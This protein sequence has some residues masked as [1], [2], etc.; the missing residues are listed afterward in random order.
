MLRWLTL[1]P[2]GLLWGS[3]RALLDFITSLPDTAVGCCCP[4]GSLAAR[5]RKLSIPVFPF[6]LADL[7][8]KGKV[9]RFS[10]LVGLIRATGG[11]RPH[12]LHVNQAGAT[13]LA[14]AASRLFRIPCVVHLRLKEDIDYLDRLQPSP[15]HLSHLITISESIDRL[16][17]DRP[18]LRRLRRTL[19]LDAYIPRNREFLTP[20]RREK[21]TSQWDF[22]CVGR[23]SPSKGQ[24]LLLE[25]LILLHER[26]L[27]F[28]AI[29]VGELNN[30]E[31]KM[32]HRAQMA[33]VADS[34]E[35]AGHSDCVHELIEASRWLVC[36][37]AYEPLGRVLFE[38]WD[39]GRPAVVGAFAGGAAT[40]VISSGGGLLFPEWTAQPLASVL[41]EALA[42]DA[43]RE[44]DLA[45]KGYR[46][47]RD[48]T[49]PAAY[50]RRFGEI[51][52]EAV[53]ER[54][55]ASK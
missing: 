25:A 41:Q 23:F 29:F 8:T 26:K 54:R 18:A 43:S 47:M 52:R 13:R 46:W 3:E 38:A 40:S 22:I 44:Q 32:K 55:H 7:H 10:A 16:V 9:K 31:L 14:L 49:E 20:L 21:V 30:H 19:L 50:A 42:M 11:F 34:V 24:E 1:D 15:E 4:E 37:S 39:A 5:L 48:A 2:A 33:G 53:A 51:L 35:F 45:A 27:P 17:A 28:R 12:V 6:F 36:P